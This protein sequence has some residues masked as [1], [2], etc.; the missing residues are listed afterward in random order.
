MFCSIYGTWGESQPFE[1]FLLRPLL[2][3]RVSRVGEPSV[4]ITTA[5]TCARAP[6]PLL[7]HQH[8][9]RTLLWSMWVY[10]WDISFFLV[11]WSELKDQPSE[12]PPCD[13]S[14]W[15][16]NILWLLFSSYGKLVEH[17]IRGLGTR[18]LVHLMEKSED[19]WESQ[20]DIL[21]CS[22]RDNLCHG[23]SPAPLPPQGMIVQPEKCTFPTQVS[24]APLLVCFQ[25]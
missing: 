9:G 21:Q 4:F 7:A 1:L 13:L 23:D 12:L 17:L 16:T 11:G 22:S 25:S 10:S 3:F 2:S 20:C 24:F 15:L 6:L 8:H 14:W 5:K 19:L 18:K